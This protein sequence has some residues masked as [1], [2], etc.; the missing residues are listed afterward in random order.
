M[1]LVFWYYQGNGQTIKI[2][3]SVERSLRETGR[4]A[5]VPTNYGRTCIA[6]TPEVEEDILNRIKKIQNAA[7]DDWALN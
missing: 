7:A 5:P 3:A 1:L 2:I 4:F 6:K